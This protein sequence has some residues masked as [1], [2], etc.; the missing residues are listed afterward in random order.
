[1]SDYKFEWKTVMNGN[2]PDW[3]TLY[4]YVKTFLEK[5]KKWEKM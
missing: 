1:M 4:Q 3:D 2:E 5:D